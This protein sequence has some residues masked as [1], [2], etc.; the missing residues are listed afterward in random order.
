M[1]GQYI[2]SDIK[3]IVYENSFTFSILELAVYEKET[4]RSRP[5]YWPS[6]K[7]FS[8]ISRSSLTDGV[9]PLV[10]EIVLKH[11]VKG[12]THYTLT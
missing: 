7:A 8:H 6:L 1:I 11:H 12:K 10:I 3:A 5:T 4:P 9:F 2:T